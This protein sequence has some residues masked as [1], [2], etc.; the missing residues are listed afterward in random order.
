MMTFDNEEEL[1]KIIRTQG[2]YTVP[3]LSF[4]LTSTS[5]ITSFI[6]EVGA[7]NLSG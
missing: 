4:L 5:L 6:G 7:A 1:R 3:L 2:E